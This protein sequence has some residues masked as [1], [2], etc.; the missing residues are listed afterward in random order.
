LVVETLRATLSDI[1]ASDGVNFV[2]HGDNDHVASGI[3]KSHDI[4]PGVCLR[5][6]NFHIRWV[7]VGKWVI[8]AEHVDFIVVSSNPRV[9]TPGDHISQDAP[10]VV[11]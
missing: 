7:P 5:I 10:A 1:P 4:L 8:S 2:T 11:D 3:G 9:P 6:V